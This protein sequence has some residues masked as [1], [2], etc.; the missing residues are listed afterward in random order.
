MKSFLALILLG[1]TLVSGCTTV[2]MQETVTSR[3]PVM[4]EVYHGYNPV[5][6]H[7]QVVHTPAPYC[8]WH[9]T[10]VYGYADVYRDG[11]NHVRVKEVAY[12]DR[13]WRCH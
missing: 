6:V 4:A 2:V 8:Y 5:V 1:T 12:V 9:E 10:P 3:P 7:S 11:Y 13:Q